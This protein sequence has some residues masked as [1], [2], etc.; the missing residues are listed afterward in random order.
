M[1]MVSVATVR[2]WLRPKTSKAQ[3][4]MTKRS[5]ALIRQIVTPGHSSSSSS[6][7]SVRESMMAEMMADQ[8][9]D[10]TPGN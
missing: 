2:A 6:G 1:G 3:R 10:A 4:N 5:E 9:P 7:S 8:T